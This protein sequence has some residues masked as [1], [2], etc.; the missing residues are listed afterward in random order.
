MTKVIQPPEMPAVEWSVR[1]QIGATVGCVDT[2]DGL[3]EVVVAGD[4]LVIDL[5]VE[6]PIAEDDRDGLAD[7]IGSVAE[8]RRTVA[9]IGL[10]DEAV[11]GLLRLLTQAIEVRET[12]LAGERMVRG[13]PVRPCRD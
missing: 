13:R 8:E 12:A 2:G 1:G 5:V 4:P 11:R 7:T 3:V 6:E 9:G 10:D